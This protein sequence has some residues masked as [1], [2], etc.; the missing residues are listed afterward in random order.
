[1]SMFC[2]GRTQITAIL[3]TVLIPAA[4]NAQ[5]SRP[6][7][8]PRNV[9]ILVHE[10]VELLDF[11]GPAEVFANASLE[12]RRA[13][14]VYTVAPAAGPTKTQQSVTVLPQ[15]TIENCPAPDILI[16]PGGNTT[17]LTENAAVMKWIRDITQKTEITMTVCTGAF[18]L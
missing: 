1:M 14:R 4:L 7:H 13:F 2:G 16:I 10:Q 17:R 5:T 18:T 15:Y 12:G 9:A 6:A 3:L 8:Q 11:A